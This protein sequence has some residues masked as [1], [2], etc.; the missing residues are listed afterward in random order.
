M[1][2]TLPVEVKQQLGG[3]VPVLSE[4]SVVSIQPCLKS[5]VPVRGSGAGEAVNCYHGIA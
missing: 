4:G 3:L 2:V 1:P 5:I